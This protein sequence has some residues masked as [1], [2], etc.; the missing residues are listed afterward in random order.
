MDRIARLAQLPPVVQ[1]FTGRVEELTELLAKVRTGGVVISGLQGMAGIGKTSLA[2]KLAHELKPDYPDA[3]IFLDLKGVDST[4]HSGV[5][6]NPL[7]SAEVMWHVVRSFDPNLKRPDSDGEVES[8][9]RTLL[10]SRPGEQPKRAILI[11]DN[12]GENKQ[13]KPLLPPPSCLLLV[14]PP[15]RL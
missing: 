12:A 4:E 8:A 5:R 1:D 13:V 15:K 14:T 3:Q 6:Q 2:V 10:N 7:S 9:Y 11:F